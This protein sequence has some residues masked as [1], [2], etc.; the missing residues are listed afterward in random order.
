VA[1]RHRHRGR[2]LVMVSDGEEK[3]I[4]GKTD[5]PMSGASTPS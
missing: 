2:S 1:A 4:A 3:G 5:A